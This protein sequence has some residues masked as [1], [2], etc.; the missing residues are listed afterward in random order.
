MSADRKKRPRPA[1]DREKLLK[2][3]PPDKGRIAAFD[4]VHA[5]LAIATEKFEHQGDGGRLG[6][7]EAPA[8]VRRGGH[9]EGNQDLVISTR[10]PFHLHR[11]PG[12]NHTPADHDRSAQ[13][14]LREQQ[15]SLDNKRRHR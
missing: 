14:Q 11:G 8:W 15:R 10:K 4:K 3:L 6:V 7:R 13:H 9:C 2:R 5:E 12:A 1:R